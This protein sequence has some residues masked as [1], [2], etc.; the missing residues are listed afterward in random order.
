MRLMMTSIQT[1]T[2]HSFLVHGRA[3]VGV[4]TEME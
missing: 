3:L 2:D 4:L 1:P